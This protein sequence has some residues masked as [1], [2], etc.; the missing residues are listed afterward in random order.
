[1][2][3]LE[4][5]QAGTDS[6]PDLGLSAGV[7]LPVSPQPQNSGRAASDCLSCCLEVD[8]VVDGNAC[9]ALPG[10]Q[11]D[12]LVIDL[13][14]VGVSGQ[15]DFLVGVAWPRHAEQQ[16]AGSEHIKEKVR[17]Q[18]KGAG[19]LFLPGPQP[20]YSLFVFGGVC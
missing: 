18:R 16:G 15:R 5:Q 11:G 14:A 3:Y 8:V 7:P 10:N 2:Q 1:M 12:A 4:K 9:R 6:Q 13:H 17:D 19:A 20:D